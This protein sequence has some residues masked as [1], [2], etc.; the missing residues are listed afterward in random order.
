MRIYVKTR[1]TSV[2]YRFLGAIPTRRWWDALSGRY[3]T[4]EKPAVAVS[5][6]GQSQGWSAAMFGVPSG[7]R[8]FRSRAVRYS[9]MI[10]AAPPDA[11]LAARWVRL[12]LEDAARADLG[13]RLDEIYVT[14]LV[15][16]AL[17][18]PLEADLP[19]AEQVLA[20]VREVLAKLPGEVPASSMAAPWAGPDSDSEAVD[21]FLAHAR[22]LARGERGLCFTSGSLSTIERARQAVAEIGDEIGVL[23]LGAQFSGVQS[24]AENGAG[25]RVLTR[26]A[27]AVGVGL[28]ALLAIWALRKV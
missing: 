28:A 6:E 5:G 22:R 2:D 4:E 18:T 19:S 21:A 25:Q 23:V 10:E 20:I 14:D 16:A 3:L 15:D 8:D 17:E 11:D 27:A 13:A 1:G 26:T 7:R 12:A 9:L 24:L